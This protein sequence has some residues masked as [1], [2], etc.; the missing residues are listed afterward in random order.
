MNKLMSSVVALSLC[1]FA[2]SARADFAGQTILGPLSLGS[3]VN[4]DNTLSNDDNDGWFSG[5]HIFDLWDGG[6]DVWRLDWAGGDMMI[7]L[8][9]DNT[10]CDP[11]LFLYVPG[12]LDESTYDNYL[13]TSPNS[14][15]VM[16]AAAGTYYILVDSSA[17][18]EGAY[19]LEVIP[20][21][22]VVTLAGVASLAMARRR[23]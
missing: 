18:S 6:D 10:Q 4:G 17:G 12:S 7:N 15:T 19:N 5:T 14:I 11:D 21:P 16:G 23:R 8:S 13:N 9:Y 20:A 22:G 2:L 1:A 3:S